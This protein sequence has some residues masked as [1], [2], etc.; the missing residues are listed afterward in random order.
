MKQMK[1]KEFSESEW[2]VIRKKVDEELE[3]EIK[4]SLKKVDKEKV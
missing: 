1:L 4:E 3:K 2:N